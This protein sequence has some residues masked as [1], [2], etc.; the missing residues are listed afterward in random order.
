MALLYYEFKALNTTSEETAG[1][2]E[3]CL[4]APGNGKSVKNGIGR[5]SLRGAVVNAS[6]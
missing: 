3:M 1:E 5:S 4:V 6:N 2:L